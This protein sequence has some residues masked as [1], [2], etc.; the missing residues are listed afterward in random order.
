MS[1]KET[2]FPSLI[3]YLKKIVEEEKDPMLVK[4]LVIQLVKLYEEVPVYPGIVN[5]CIG[6]AA[7][8]VKPEELEVGQRVFIKSR[9]DRISGTVSAKDGEGITLKAVKLLTNEDELDLGFREIQRATIINHNV[10]KELWPALV[11]DKEHK[12]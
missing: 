12:F 5:M 8:A 10:L 6:S 3:K 7:R 11:F 2:D 4:E 9:E 1:F